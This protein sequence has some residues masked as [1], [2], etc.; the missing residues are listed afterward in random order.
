MKV[1][2]NTVNRKQTDGY[3]HYELSK[4]RKILCFLCKENFLNQH[5]SYKKTEQT[6]WIEENAREVSDND[7]NNNLKT[8]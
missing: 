4:C 8:N 6:E 1:V 3:L 5:N 7:E 2:V